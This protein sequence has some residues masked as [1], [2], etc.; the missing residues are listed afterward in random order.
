MGYSVE[1][2][3]L[4]QFMHHL[5]LFSGIKSVVDLGSQELHFSEQDTT[6]HP[7]REIIRRTLKLM[8]GPEV[9]DTDL[10]HLANRASVG[11]FFKLTGVD[12]TPLDAD[13]WYG[14]PFDFNLDT[15]REKDKGAYCLTMNAGTTEH[16]M[17]QNNAFRIVHELTRPGGYIVHALPFLGSINHGF[18]NYNPNFFWDLAR[19]NSYEML[20][21]WVSPSAGACLIPWNDEVGRHLKVPTE[22]GS[23]ISIWCLL[24][25]EHD[26]DYC[27]PFQK[28]YEAAQAEE[29]LAR[30]NY[31][32]DGRL[33]SGV[34]V[35]RIT[36]NQQP[37]E[38]VSGSA[39]LNELGRRIKRRIGLGK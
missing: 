38:T 21:I 8:G 26:L 2:M 17:D 20:G 31:A 14:E 37:L 35:Y 28:G 3:S 6:S 34:D 36:Q 25:K 30:Y 10:A 27:V 12:Y 13:A 29:N 5:D 11:E 23:G 1:T 39:L 32:L 15:V 19:F 22:R 18:F 7:Y 9:N 4:F 16:L 24:R 33:M